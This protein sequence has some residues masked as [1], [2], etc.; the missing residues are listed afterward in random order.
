MTTPI[1]QFYIVFNFDKPKWYQFKYKARVFRSQRANLKKLN[2]VMSQISNG[3]KY[4]IKERADL[5]GGQRF[6][7][8]TFSE[9]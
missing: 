6:V 5:G 8:T 2:Q 4:T 3:S 9:Q 1:K 7:F